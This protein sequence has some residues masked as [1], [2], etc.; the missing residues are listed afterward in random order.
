YN[1]AFLPADARMIVAVRPG[2]LLRRRD[3]RS[4]L[5][6]LRQGSLL[7]NRFVIPPEEV[8]QLVV[9][10]EGM[11]QAPTGPDRSPLIPPPS[12]F[13]LRMTKP[14]DWKTLRSQLFGG[15]HQEARHDGQPY[16]RTNVN[17]PEPGGWGLYLPGDRTLV[18]AQEELLRELIEDRDAPASRHPW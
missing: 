11:P 17:S 1:L 5:D 4:L 16:V 7:K 18:A 10:W 13:V 6:S 3:V 14:Q 9:F 12:G 8:E 15:T 2:S